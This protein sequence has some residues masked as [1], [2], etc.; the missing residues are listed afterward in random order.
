M[1][2]T[3]CSNCSTPFDL[4][5]VFCSSCGTSTAAGTTT[6]CPQCAKA[7]GRDARFCKYC[8]FDLSETA[9]PAPAPEPPPAASTF[10]APPAHAV[11]GNGGAA[12]TPARKSSRFRRLTGQTAKAFIPLLVWMVI[13]V[14]TG[15]AS[16]L[17]WVSLPAGINYGPGVVFGVAIFLFGEFAALPRAARWRKLYSF[18]VIVGLS[19]IGWYLALNFGEGSGWGFLSPLVKSIYSALPIPH[20]LMAGLVGGSCIVA[21]ELLCWRFPL[22]RW[23]YAVCLIAVAGMAGLLGMFFLGGFVGL[24]IIWQA[25]VLAAHV[26]AYGMSRKWLVISTVVFVT[27]A[28]GISGMLALQER[29]EQERAQKETAQQEAANARAERD[30]ALEE[31]RASLREKENAERRATEAQAARE[32][33]EVRERAGQYIN[34]VGRQL[35]FASGVYVSNGFR[36]THEYKIDSLANGAEAS[37]TLNLNTGWQYNLISACDRDCSDIDIY[38]YDGLGNQIASD[39][40]RDDKPV[41]TVNVFRGGE[42]RVKVVMYKCGSSPCVY[43]IGAFGRG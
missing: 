28:A 3:V 6:T 35:D 4:D 12:V 14:V 32:A 17:M 40:S 41:V 23:M 11:E 16:Y 19:V 37:F 33:A 2:T 36:K 27:L 9:Q 38:V 22:P 30:R 34:Q 15:L 1:Q 42:F 26:V 31:Q 24:L 5:A 18:P 8:A 25:L 43:G 21:S 39:S 20:F 29:V 13:G 7:I 10:D